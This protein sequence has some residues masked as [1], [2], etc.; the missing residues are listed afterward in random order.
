MVGEDT[1]DVAHRWHP[2][3]SARIKVEKAMF[4]GKLVDT[5]LRVFKD[6]TKAV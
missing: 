3:L 6:V 5:G 4:L 1:N 2:R